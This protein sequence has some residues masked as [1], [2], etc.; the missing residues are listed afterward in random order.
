[1]E[2]YKHH[3]HTLFIQL[4]FAYIYLLCASDTFTFET[5]LYTINLFSYTY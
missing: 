2:T 1:M 4:Y 5:Y 3:I